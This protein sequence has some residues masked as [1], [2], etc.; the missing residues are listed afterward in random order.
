M[1]A[2]AALD[3]VLTGESDEEL[4]GA[5]SSVAQAQAAVEQLETQLAKLTIAAPAGGVVLDRTVLEGELAVPGV[6]LVTVADLDEVFWDLLPELS[7]YSI[8]EE[9]SPV[10]GLEKASSIQKASRMQ[11]VP[12]DQ[13]MYV[14]DSITDV[15]AFRTVRREGGLAVSFNGNR[16][17]V[18]EADVAMVCPRAEPMLPFSRAFLKGGRAAVEGADWGGDFSDC[19]CTWLE[20]ADEE[21]VVAASERMRK[22]VRGEEIGR[23]G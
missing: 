14:G 4:A 2:Q 6:T 18:E 7:V 10:G 21:P 16:W 9:V 15:E 23:L 22:E 3:L 11:E 13:V 19:S 1:Q 12:M 20:G 17:A 8:V 5:Q